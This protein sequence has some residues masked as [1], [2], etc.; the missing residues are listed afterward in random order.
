M[1]QKELNTEYVLALRSRNV[2][3]YLPCYNELTYD[4]F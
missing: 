1:E 3:L 2:G 4:S